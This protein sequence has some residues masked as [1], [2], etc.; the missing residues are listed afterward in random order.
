MCSL[1]DLNE[2]RSATTEA[3]RAFDSQKREFDRTTGH[4]QT[5][6]L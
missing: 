1:Q 6:K 5:L 2:E 3:T 4:I